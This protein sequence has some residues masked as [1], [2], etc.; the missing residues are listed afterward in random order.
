MN[1]LAKATFISSAA[2]LAACSTASTPTL[3]TTPGIGAPNVAGTTYSVTTDGVTDTIIGPATRHGN[4]ISWAGAGGSNT[5][6]G[7][8]ETADVLAIGAM[9][10]AA[11][12]GTFAGITG[13]L[14]PVQT[15]GTASYNTQFSAVIVEPSG[16]STITNDY[17]S[18][19]TINVDFGAGTV[20]G[21]QFA[22]GLDINGTITGSQF[23]GTTAFQGNVNAS[24]TTVPMQGGFYG[25]D[26]IAGVFAGDGLAGAFGGTL[27]P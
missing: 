7:G 9:Y 11:P 13:T 8:Y 23:S 26:T 21:S 4:F 6:G 22:W 25:T 27:N 1:I 10:K 19:A 14:S 24:A 20:A 3:I 17:N 15:S 5:M 18:I 16:G 12:H 2:F